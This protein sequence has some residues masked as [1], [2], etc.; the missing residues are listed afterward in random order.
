MTRPFFTKDRISHFDI[1]DRH[2]EDALAQA[3]QRL[4]E[5]YLIDFQVRTL[6]A[7]IGS[8]QNEI[9]GAIWLLR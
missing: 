4:A 2:A 1:F 9:N 5:G 6:P 3:K 7:D 8:S